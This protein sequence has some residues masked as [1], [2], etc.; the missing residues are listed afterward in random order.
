M[1]YY[2][3]TKHIGR[4]LAILSLFSGNTAADSS[5]VTVTLL[6]PYPC[7]PAAAAA[8]T[9]MLKHNEMQKKSTTTTSSTHTDTITTTL[10]DNKT[11]EN[12]LFLVRFHVYTFDRSIRFYLNFRVF[13]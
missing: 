12:L 4:L 2:K 11:Q 9:A 10:K 5:A 1:L 3:N 13:N 8:A 6:L 7:P